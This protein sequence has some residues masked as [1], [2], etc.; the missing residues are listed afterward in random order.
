M[1]FKELTLY[2]QWEKDINLILLIFETNPSEAE[3]GA[4]S[5]APIWPPP[6]S[7]TLQFKTNH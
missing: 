4:V 2:K 7:H 1:L 5:A 6:H 3:N